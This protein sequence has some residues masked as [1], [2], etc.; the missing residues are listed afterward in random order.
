MAPAL[1]TIKAVLTSLKKLDWP[2]DDEYFSASVKITNRAVSGALSALHFE[3]E[4]SKR[5]PSTSLTA[6]LIAPSI[7]CEFS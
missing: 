2:T 4:H 3:N 7:D 1:F 6:L 5:N